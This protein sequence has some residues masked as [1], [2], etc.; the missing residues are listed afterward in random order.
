M[1]A[2]HYTVFETAMGFCG[3]A[4]GA[5]GVARFQLPTKTA[6]FRRAADPAPR[7]G[8]YVGRSLSRRRRGD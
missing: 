8:S 7:A 2:Q 4:W 6:D 1:S 5:D 3:I